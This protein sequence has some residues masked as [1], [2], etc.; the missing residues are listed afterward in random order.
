LGITAGALLAALGAAAWQWTSE[1]PTTRD[2]PA[3]YE[4]SQLGDIAPD[5]RLVD[6]EGRSVALDNFRGKVVVLT[7]TNFEGA[8]PASALIVQH[9][10]ALLAASGV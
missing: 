7:L 9:V 8:P 4:G 3:S 6:Q 10:K 5:F 1:A 2:T